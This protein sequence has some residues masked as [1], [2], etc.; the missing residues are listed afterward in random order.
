MRR[1]RNEHPRDEAL[2]LSILYPVLSAAQ[3][4]SFSLPHCVQRHNRFSLRPS[5]PNTTKSS[6][7]LQTNLTFV[8]TISNHSTSAVHLRFYANHFDQKLLADWIGPTDLSVL[9]C[10]LVQE[11]TIGLACLYYTLVHIGGLVV[12]S[13]S[14]LGVSSKSKQVVIIADR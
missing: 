6:S 12:Y 10:I 1:I 13:V 7:T 3:H 9:A 2:L 14:S 4:T 5:S 8:S 11:A